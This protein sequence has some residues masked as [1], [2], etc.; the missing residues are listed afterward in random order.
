MERWSHDEFGELH[1]AMG[2]PP[3]EAFAEW[4]ELGVRS[5]QRW[6]SEPGKQPN[7]PVSRNLDAKLR[8]A[9]RERIVWLPVYLVN[10]MH[11]RDLLRL[12][13][14]A[15]SI[16]V[17]GGSLVWN[18]R[19]P[20]VSTATLGGLEEVTTV[21]ASKYNTSPAHTLLGAT[22]GHL[23]EVSGLL[24]TAVMKPNQRQ[25]LESI[26][27]DVAIF[28][29]SLS[30][31]S[32]KSALAD[33]HLELAKKMARQA[34]NEALLAQV[35]AKQALLDYYEQSPDQAGSDPHPRIG[36]LEEAQALAR[37]HAPPIVQMAISGWLAEDKATAKDGYGA[38]EALEQAG[39]ALH[40]AQAKGPAGIGF[41]SS[42]GGYS[43]WG[44]GSLEGFRGTVEL[45]L[46]RHSAIDT[47]TASLRLKKNPGSRAIG[48]VDL[49]IALIAQKEP[50][51]AC[52]RLSQAHTIGLARGSSTILHHVF[53]ARMLMPPEWNGLKCVRELDE[54]LGRGE[55]TSSPRT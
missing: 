32:G 49:A 15:A 44:E 25:R 38:D 24:K 10:Q 31:L 11:R 26:A 41:C 30:M 35:L 52:D 9:V 37:R 14:A 28:V 8:Q 22:T 33:A 47:I 34:G 1:R 45:S 7:V 40:K 54:R 19:L 5:V 20:R 36:L 6:L 46:G 3:Q 50:E 55:G 29:G 21:L 42:A 51:A 53:S 48:L 2:E 4:L 12:L 16:P 23:E 18:A 13:Y 39:H 43:G 27:A 17:G